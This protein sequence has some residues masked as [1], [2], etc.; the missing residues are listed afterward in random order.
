[1]R[2]NVEVMDL[3]AIYVDDTRITARS[4]KWGPQVMVAVFTCEQKEAVAQCLERGHTKAVAHISEEP[5]KS[6]R[7]SA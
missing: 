4:T 2:V 5:L 6:K 1:M 7:D 3:N